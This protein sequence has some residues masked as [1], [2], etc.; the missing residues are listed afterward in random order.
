MRSEKSSNFVISL[1]TLWLKSAQGTFCNT[2]KTNS[3]SNIQ[4]RND[5]NEK[6]YTEIAI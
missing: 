2:Q 1:R 4:Q 5:E 6:F 3:D